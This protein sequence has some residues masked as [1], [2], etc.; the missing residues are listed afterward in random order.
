[1]KQRQKSEASVEENVQ[2]EEDQRKYTASK[3]FVRK[4]SDPELRTSKEIDSK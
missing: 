3:T 4:G 2:T 1:V